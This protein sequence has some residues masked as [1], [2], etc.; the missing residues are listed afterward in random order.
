MA[1]IT[2]MLAGLVKRKNLS[3]DAVQ[4]E[5]RN[6]CGERV[7]VSRED[8]DSRYSE[9]CYVQH[10]QVFIWEV[11]PEVLMYFWNRNDMIGEFQVPKKSAVVE[12]QPGGQMQIL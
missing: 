2:S 3:K 7:L 5:I 10:N 4:V 12:L 1:K 9:S 8:R 11:S 6:Y